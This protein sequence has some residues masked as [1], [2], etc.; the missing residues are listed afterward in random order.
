[1]AGRSLRSDSAARCAR[2]FALLLCATPGA[3]LLADEAAIRRNLPARLPDLPGIDEVRPAAMPGLW[4][5]RLGNEVIYSDGEGAFVFEGDLI[6]TRRQLNLTD[7][8]E[9]ALKHI[10]LAKLPLQD[11]VVWKKGSGA[12]RIVVFADPNC[13]YCRRLERELNLVPDITVYTFVIPILGEDSVL[14]ARAIWCAAD[15]GST[16]RNWMVNGVTPATSVTCD[17][18]ALTRNLAL[19]RRH[20]VAGTPS[21]VFDDGERIAGVIDADQFEQK[22][23]ALKSK[24]RG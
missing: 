24:P 6:D 1:M 4:E 17:T 18:S 11:A 5:V 8:R 23:A 15:R 20:G 14:K 9:T 21:L 19:Q 16:W 2:W 10:D 3:A 7:Q 12:R 13:T 22:F